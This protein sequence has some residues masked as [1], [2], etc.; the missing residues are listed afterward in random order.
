MEN[1]K[2][3][4]WDLDETFWS[5]TLSEEGVCPIEKNIQLVKI[6]TQRGIIN[7]IVSKNDFEQARKKLI[8]FGIW[9]YFVFPAIEWQPKGILIKN[10]IH[11][12]QLREV[13]VLFLDDNHLNL[14][15]AK[16]YNPKLNIHRPVFVEEILGHPAFI[17][18]NDDRHS[19]L[20]QY[21]LLEEKAVAMTSFNSNIEFLKA[22]NI[23]IHFITYL[24]GQKER[25]LE[26]LERTNQLNFTKVRS[27]SEEVE[28]LIDNPDF[29]SAIIKVTDNYG[30]YGI[31]GFYSLDRQN[32][33][34]KHFVFSCR[35]L[36]LGI[37]QYVYSKLKFPALDI[38]PEVAEALDESFPDWITETN[39]EK[40]FQQVPNQ[41]KQNSRI[42]ILFKGCCEFTQMLFYLKNNGIV[43]EEETNYVSKENLAIHQGH[44][45]VLLD[46]LTISPKDKKYLEESVHIPFVD[47]Y[48]YKT[49]V[50]DLGFDCLV[51]SLHMDYTQELYA[52]EK[53]N[54]ILPYGGYH[55]YW[56]DNNSHSDIVKKIN[57]RGLNSINEQHLGVFASE[58]RHLGQ[59]SP[60]HFLENLKQIREK[61]PSH[62]PIVFINGAEVQNPKSLEKNA[63]MRHQMMNGVL[64]GFL[65]K[66][67]NCHL[68]D[69]RKI[70]TQ[71]S[72]L[73]LNSR[74]FQREIYSKISL[75]LLQILNIAVDRKIGTK[76]SLKSKLLSRAGAL[77]E[78][79][80][81]TKR[82]LLD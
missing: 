23:K 10:I 75:A 25:I 56:T 22:S 30:D 81:K 82:E 34:L 74:H 8:A 61:I 19:R 37:P 58:F 32:H 18:K 6:L 1:I 66:N 71:E 76:L 13:N 44:S 45:Q 14:E 57:P 40:V 17:G 50:F 11:Q 15:E 51:Y 59:I 26:L 31:V 72:Q 29:S 54:L 12:C 79:A 73:T 47:A 70:V 63:K 62:I 49:K 38:V 60:A 64:D 80:K 33:H 53:R 2:L 20:K 4:I 78:L 65:E 36:S 67:E 7:S 9:D 27:A 16:F 5:G 28:A 52:H 42:K 39:S 41:K 21:R 48:F 55:S 24:A 43:V 77:V 35:I 46:A 69:L 68:L 3:V